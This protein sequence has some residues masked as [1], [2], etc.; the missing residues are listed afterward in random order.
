MSDESGPR[1]RVVADDGGL[2]AKALAGAGLL[3]SDET[4]DVVIVAGGF[5]AVREA[6]RTG[7]R[8]VALTE[9]PERRTVAVLLDL[10]AAGVG[11]VNS[12]PEVI[13]A[14]VRTIVA[15][16][17]VIPEAA[18][19]TVRRPALSTRQKQVLS[20]VVLGMSNAEIAERLFLSEATVKSHL[21]KIFSE[22]G[23]RS[24]KQAVDLIHDP[25]S[26]LGPGIL[27]IPQASRLQQG[28]GRPKF[29]D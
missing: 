27:G 25:T 6:V 16:Y 29:G 12:P 23:V 13:V 14:L 8:V 20:L 9:Q 2:L 4:P 18:R 28:Y 5:D 26:G 15:G 1:C 21:T 19:Q 22:L 24:R 11:G 7:V 10:G 17:T 3:L